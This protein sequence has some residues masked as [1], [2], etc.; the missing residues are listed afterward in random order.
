MSG[1]SK[2]TSMLTLPATRNF[3]INPQKF[4]FAISPS[5]NTSEMPLRNRAPKQKA[6]FFSV[7]LFF[8]LTL[9]AQN[10]NWS[11]T[12]SI[13]G[14]TNSVATSVACDALGNVYACG[15][16]DSKSLSFGTTTLKNDT[17]GL[18][19]AGGTDIY[20]VKYKAN[21]TVVWAKGF[22]GSLSDNAYGLCV[23][24]WGY[25]YITGTFTSSK[26]FFGGYG[27]RNSGGQDLFLAKLDPNGSTIWARGAGGNGIDVANGVCTDSRGNVCI[28][29]SFGSSQ[30][31]IGN[32]ILADTCPYS[33]PFVAK[34]DSSGNVLWAKT[35]TGTNSYNG[36]YGKSL[37]ADTSS[38]IYV[39]GG[40]SFASIRF[41]THTLINAGL[42]NVFT[43]K[44]D[45][46]GNEVWAK[47]AG[48]MNQDAG[49]GI[50]TDR[51]GNAYVCGSFF[52][53]ALVFG[54]DTLH[55]AGAGD[56]FLVK[57]DTNGNPIW[58]TGAGGTGTDEASGISI[59]PNGFAYLAGSF[60]SGILAI[61]TTN[62]NNQGNMNIFMAEYNFNGTPLWARSAGGTSYDYG[63]SS[64]ADASGNAYIAGFF[65]SSSIDFGSIPLVSS[66]ATNMYVAKISGVT[67]IESYSENKYEVH[68]FPTPAGTSASF[69]LN[70][71]NAESFDFTL[72][73]PQGKEVKH[74]AGIPG[75]QFEI[76][77]NGLSSGIYFYLLRDANQQVIGRGKIVFE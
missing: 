56:L 66:G 22:G 14:N 25:V 13:S 50:G 6:F 33:V 55:N 75:S 74:L 43:V 35:A 57:Y 1:G 42:T 51:Q 23:D 19:T 65:A 24:R 41:G 21:G 62:L 52:S 46:A 26:L 20:V 7:T 67:G 54:T 68:V 29:G 16:F 5:L 45:T 53:P 69:I 9:T 2:E 27:L 4:N 30:F 10:W 36:N 49:S 28:T 32:Q 17:L 59:D 48:G 18:D 70:N 34:F 31:Y 61:G 58:S 38:N 73:N 40:F 60:S 76:Q 39:T 15:Y 77:R 64:F 47:S 72:F 71:Q 12:A 8:S 63:T 37:C 11:G 3:W 44:Y